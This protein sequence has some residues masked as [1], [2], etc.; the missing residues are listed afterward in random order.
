[1]KRLLLYIL[2]LAALLFSGCKEDNWMDW[3]LQNEM[4]LVENAKKEGVITTDSG[5]QYKILYQGNPSDAK[6][7]DAS[8][9]ICSYTGTLIN[10]YKFDSSEGTSLTV[11]GVVKGFGEGLKKIHAHGDIEIYIPQELGYT[12][13]GSGTEGSL[14]G[15][16]IPPYSTLIFKVHVSAVTK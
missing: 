1:M 3:K 8:T 13:E 15:S 16:F 7:D 5:L 11:S 12:D 14:S 9:V 10:G 6:P 2:P 4:W